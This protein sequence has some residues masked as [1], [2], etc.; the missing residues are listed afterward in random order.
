VFLSVAGDVE[1]SYMQQIGVV[2]EEPESVVAPLTQQPADGAGGMVMIEVLRCWITADR[3][4]VVLGRP[5]LIDSV[6]RE[7]VA[8]IEVRGAV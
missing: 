5:H 3:A 7:L 1:R 4:A 8:T 6:P 2:T